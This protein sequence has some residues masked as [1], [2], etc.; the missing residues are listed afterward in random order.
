VAYAHTGVDPKYM[1]ISPVSATQLA[2]KKT[3]AVWT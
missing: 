1:G 3:V 2:L